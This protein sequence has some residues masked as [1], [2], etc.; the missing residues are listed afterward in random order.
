M[1]DKTIL[2]VFILCKFIPTNY[3]NACKK[4]G[5]EVYY[6][7]DY[8][9]TYE[10]DCLLLPGGGDIAS[11]FYNQKETACFDVDESFDLKT[12]SW[13]AWFVEKKKPV[14]GICKGMQYINVWFGGSLHQ[15]IKNHSCPNEKFVHQ[16]EIRPKT[17][18][19]QIF[20]KSLKVNSSHHQSI[21]KLG[22]NIK[23]IAVCHDGTIEAIMHEDKR[24]FGFQWHPERMFEENGNKIFKF[25]YLQTKKAKKLKKQKK[26]CKKKFQK[27]KISKKNCKKKKS[28]S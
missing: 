14:L 26:N 16:I 12:F 23:E 4:V 18:L 15:D 25:F 2:R 1:Q 19:F 11:R 22:E 3:I 20:G 24:I 17:F 27:K 10:C 7:E 5:F 6:G 8:S 21:Q 13:L 28:F 9:S